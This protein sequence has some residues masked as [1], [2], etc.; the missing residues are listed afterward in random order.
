MTESI[1]WQQ[2]QRTCRW[3]QKPFLP[4]TKWQ[5]MCCYKCSYFHQNSKRQIP[6]NTG[7]C[8]RCGLSLQNKNNKAIYCS[9]A[10]KSM[11][12]AFKHRGGSRVGTARRRLIIERDKATCYLC[13]EVIPISDIELDHLLPYSR[14]GDSSPSNL[15]VTCLPCNRTRSNRID[16]EQLLRLQ[17]LRPCDD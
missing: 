13:K 17:E 15:S 14:G 16:V 1:T 5:M 11:D 9:R 7:L 12:H 8:M 6:V 2:L 10:C 4:I 3:C